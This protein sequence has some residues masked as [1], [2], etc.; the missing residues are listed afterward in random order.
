MTKRN[1]NI[2]WVLKV[3][4][5]SG[6][7]YVDGYWVFKPTEAE[8]DIFLEDHYPEDYEAETIYWELFS[9]EGIKNEN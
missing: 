9:L 8:I 5:E 3:D 1:G 7:H 2:I 4:T 6:D